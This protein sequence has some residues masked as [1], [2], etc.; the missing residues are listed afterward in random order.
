LA[1]KAF[2]RA[3]REEKPEKHYTT[4]GGEIPTHVD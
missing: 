1:T 4:P 3:E 2:R